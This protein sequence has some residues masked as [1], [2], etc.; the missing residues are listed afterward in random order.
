MWLFVVFWVVCVTL[1]LTKS[2]GAADKSFLSVSQP[3]KGIVLEITAPQKSQNSLSIVHIDGQPVHK[4]VTEEILYV[5]LKHVS[6]DQI[7]LRSLYVEAE[8]D[9]RD[10]LT[11]SV[12]QEVLRALGCA[13]LC[14]KRKETS[15]SDKTKRDILSVLGT[16]KEAEAIFGKW[17]GE[18]HLTEGGIRMGGMLENIE[19]PQRLSSKQGGGWTYTRGGSTYPKSNALVLQLYPGKIAVQLKNGKKVW[20]PLQII[21]TE[22]SKKNQNHSVQSLMIYWV[23]AL[24]CVGDNDVKGTLGQG[25]RHVHYLSRLPE[26][27][28]GKLAQRWSDKIEQ[29]WYFQGSAQKK[30]FQ[31]ALHE[32]AFSQHVLCSVDISALGI[33]HTGKQS[34]PN[35]TAIAMRG[36]GPSN[37][38]EEW[39]FSRLSSL[40]QNTSDPCPLRFAWGIRLFAPHI[41]AIPLK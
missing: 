19:P 20:V 37:S 1:L 33:V 24:A 18:N 13:V 22:N 9:N 26:D 17:D 5:L 30:T 11:N 12:R 25:V 41:Q 2:L 21:Y 7:V 14:D 4:G 29:V 15:C 34:L 27:T 28:E 6:K 38:P 23:R 36:F 39:S 35:F 31:G 3:P 16:P 8:E 32:Q 10:F 40:K